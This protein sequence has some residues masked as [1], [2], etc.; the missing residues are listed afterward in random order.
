[1]VLNPWLQDSGT[2]CSNLPTGTN[3]ANPVLEII[4]N[5]GKLLEENRVHGFCPEPHLHA[6]T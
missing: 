6:D 3:C 2:N 1:M 4:Q 5:F